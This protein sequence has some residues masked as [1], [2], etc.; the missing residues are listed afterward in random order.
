MVVSGSGSASWLGHSLS[1]ALTRAADGTLSAARAAFQSLSIEQDPLAADIAL[2]GVPETGGFQDRTVTTTVDEIELKIDVARVTKG[3]AD[4]AGARGDSATEMVHI[5]VE[6]TVDPLTGQRTR[7][8]T[9]PQ[10]AT[11]GALDAKELDRIAGGLADGQGAFQGVIRSTTAARS[12]I[13]TT[14]RGWKRA[15]AAWYKL[16]RSRPMSER[17]ILPIPRKPR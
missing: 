8:T 3:G 7:V 4:V 9:D 12:P 2:Y 14:K 17:S 15:R 16:S 13:P 1:E 5:R 11:S 10:Q 6:T